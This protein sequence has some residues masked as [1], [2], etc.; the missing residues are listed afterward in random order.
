[1]IQSSIAL[2]TFNVLVPQAMSLRV[3]ARLTEL[4]VQPPRSRMGN[5]S[6]KGPGKGPK[7]QCHKSSPKALLS[8]V[9]WGLSPHNN[10]KLHVV[11]GKP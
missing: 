11:F 3:K 1:M 2:T 4:F 9:S 6:G 10:R 7:A 5:R 8:W